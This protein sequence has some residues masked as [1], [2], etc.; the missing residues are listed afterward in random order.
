M[1]KSRKIYRYFL[2]S[3]FLILVIYLLFWLVTNVKINACPPGCV[4]INKEGEC[5]CTGIRPK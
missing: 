3:V 5:G 2:A 4:L 1:S